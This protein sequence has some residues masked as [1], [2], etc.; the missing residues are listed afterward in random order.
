[1]SVSPMGLLEEGVT[2]EGASVNLVEG[3][4]ASMGGAACTR[5]TRGAHSC[6]A[7]DR[8]SHASRSLCRGYGCLSSALSGLLA[9]NSRSPWQAPRPGLLCPGSH[10]TTLSLCFSGRPSDGSGDRG[11]HRISMSARGWGARCPASH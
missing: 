1:M 7:W 8:S 9:P 4:S 6:E 2:V 11:D 5:G 10:S 3:N